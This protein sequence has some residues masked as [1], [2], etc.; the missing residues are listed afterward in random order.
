LG[1][2]TIGSVGL[3]TI[4]QFDPTQASGSRWTLKT[5]TL[6]VPLAYVPATTIGTL[7][8]TGGG[9]TVA[10]GALTD[11]NNSYVYNPVADVISPIANIPRATGETRGV[12]VGNKLW[13]LGGGRTAPN[14]SNEVDIYDPVAGT[15]SIGMPFATA[16]RNFPADGDGSRVFLIGGYDSTGV[17]FV[18][19]MQNYG[20]GVCATPTATA[21]NTPTNTPTGHGHGHGNS[22]GNSK[23]YTEWRSTG[24][25]GNRNTRT[26]T[27]V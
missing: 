5:A 6:P 4:Y 17:G 14:P 2:F 12:N 18:T 1:G 19:T 9:S 23:L 25:V 7:I 26:G 24:T 16:R 20:S 13:V 21:T 27:Q 11:S 8:F 3:N 10:A 22:N 15:W